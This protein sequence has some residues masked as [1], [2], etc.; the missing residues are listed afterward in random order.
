M[1]DWDWYS[2]VSNTTGGIAVIFLAFIGKALMGMRRDFHKFMAEHSWLLATTLWT[3]DKVL[4][5]M[6]KLDMPMTDAPPRD[7]PWKDQ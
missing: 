1:K 7:L 4:V 5:I 3:R 2:I 6:A